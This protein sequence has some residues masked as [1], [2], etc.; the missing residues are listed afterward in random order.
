MYT[1]LGVLAAAVIITITAVTTPS[2]MAAAAVSGHPLR[3]ETNTG[4]RR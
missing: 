1:N 2:Q 3:G 4:T